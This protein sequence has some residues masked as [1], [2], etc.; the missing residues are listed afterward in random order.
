MLKRIVNQCENAIGSADWW[1]THPRNFDVQCITEL[2][3]QISV[4]IYG[5]SSRC[6]FSTGQKI[7]CKMH[8]NHVEIADSITSSP[9][10]GAVV[11][12]P[13]QLL[14]VNAQLLPKNIR[15]PNYCIAHSLQIG[16]IHSTR[17]FVEPNHK[18]SLL[19]DTCFASAP[20]MQVSSLN[21]NQETRLCFAIGTWSTRF[22]VAKFLPPV[23][24][25]MDPPQVVILIVSIRKG[26][27]LMSD[28][29]AFH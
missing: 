9:F 24:L 26:S 1:N 19:H 2:C 22:N 25:T 16:G 12:H 8:S 13:R 29:M 20:T 7:V 17:I 5:C 6:P 11:V 3:L 10:C 28:E 4:R 15:S 27:M 18:A 14:L 21:L 23:F